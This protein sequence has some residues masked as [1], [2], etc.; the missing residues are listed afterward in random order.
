VIRRKLDLIHV[1]IGTAGV[2]G[3]ADV[4]MATAPTTAYLMLG[5]RCAMNCAFCAQARSSRAGEA[6]LSRVRWPEFSLDLVCERLQTAESNGGLQR[7]CIQ[8]TAGQEYVQAALDAVLKIRAATALPLNVAILP[9][10][11]EQVSELM[12]S[13]VERIGYG[14]DA[15]CERI[16]RSVKGRHWARILTLI[17][18]TAKLYPGRA[19][20]HLIVGLGET[21]REMVERML[22]T[23]DLGLGIGLFAF[24]PVRGTLLAGRQ[25]PRLA[26][27]RRMQASRWL[28]QHHGA[29]VADFEFLRGADGYETLVGIRLAG[30]RDLL[31][32]GRAFRTAGCPACNRPYYNERPGGTIYNYPRALTCDEARQA[33]REM[34]FEDQ[35]SADI[36]R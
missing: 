19:A 33:L 21:E 22:W 14:L 34:E 36:S 15:A 18:E 25:Q 29:Q 30:W 4:P 3:L 16:F 5:G 27:Y 10:D 9:R 28:I 7:C 8:V 13:G 23:R 2:L 1:S 6:V 24:T 20:V 17:E 32:S 12:E 31:A 26:Q 11:V 35:H